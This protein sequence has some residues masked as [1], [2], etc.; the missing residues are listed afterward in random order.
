[1][2]E[3]PEKKFNQVHAVQES[4]VDRTAQNRGRIVVL[5]E[6]IASHLEQANNW[7][8]LARNAMLEIELWI[9]GYA[10]ALCQFQTVAVERADFKIGARP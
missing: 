5:E 3:V 8:R 6:F 2:D 4:K 7:N 10:G 1:M 9:H